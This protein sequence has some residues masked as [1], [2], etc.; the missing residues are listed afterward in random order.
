MNKVSK[1]NRN[2]NKA[3]KLLESEGWKVY[4]AIR[5]KY[6]E[7]DILGLFDLIAYRDGYFKLIQVKS[8]VCDKETRDKIR[9]FITD[10]HFV[11]REIWVY[12]DYDREA[13]YVIRWCRTCEQEF[14][15]NKGNLQH[16]MGFYCKMECY[17]VAQRQTKVTLECEIC[18]KEFIV[19]PNRNKARFCSRECY[20]KGLSKTMQGEKHPHWRGGISTCFTYNL[21]NEEWDRL[22]R[23]VYKRDNF[24]CQH[25]GKTDCRLDA[26][27]II[28]YRISFDNSI[29]NLLTL[30]QTC[31]GKEE[32]RIDKI[33][34]NYE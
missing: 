26:H 27:H 29:E 22:R 17:R 25:C 1:G 3:R 34:Q 12:V 28:P 19:T 13:P 32:W 5:T 21:S 2:Q 16:G 14:R 15:P 20:G 30:C 11:I 10:G 7:I 18:E 33:F 24:T 8:N 9:D 6:H 31:H 23:E 4:T